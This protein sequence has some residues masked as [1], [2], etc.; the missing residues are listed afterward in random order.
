MMRAEISEMV[1]IMGKMIDNME[2]L[3]DELRCLQKDIEIRLDVSDF[4]S[5]KQKTC[6][7]KK[8]HKKKER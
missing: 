6:Q 1:F 2:R 3:L 8:G 4:K 5:Q 7:V